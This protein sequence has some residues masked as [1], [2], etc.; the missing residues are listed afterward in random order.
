M[1]NTALKNSSLLFE[2]LSCELKSFLLD[3]P[4]NSIS[5][6]YEFFTEQTAESRFGVSCVWQ[7]Y[8]FGKR[9]HNRGLC[10]IDYYV[11][12]RHVALICSTD[13]ESYLIDPYLL[14]TT[15]IAIN[16]PFSSETV[17]PS[18]NESFAYPYRTI[19]KEQYKPSK[20]STTF[21]PEFNRLRLTYKKYSPTKNHY[22]VS[23]VF[24]MDLEKKIPSRPPT[25]DQV[26]PLLHHGEQNNLSI[27]LVHRESHELYELI[28]PIAHQHG[29]PIKFENLVAR[30]NN[31]KV[32][33]IEHSDVFSNH[34]D[35]MADS[36]Q[37]PT[38]AL[39]DFV[40][41]GVAIYEQHAPQV[42]EYAE[43]K[44]KDE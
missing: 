8:E 26:I 29:K 18:K 42:I 6:F 16:K 3:V 7:S 22:V 12:G 13:D 35:A 44:L 25:R 15:P 40:L 19:T 14:H 37:C 2:I 33:T 31:G 34:I 11:D 9:L 20:L 39:I 32:F 23:R 41:G 17:E 10:D 21:Y 38:Q 28:Y 43:L 5:Q 27:R 1:I 30:T 4:Y 36:L 24:N